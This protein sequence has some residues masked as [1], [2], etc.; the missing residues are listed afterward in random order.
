MDDKTITQKG[1]WYLVFPKSKPSNSALPCNAM[2][3]ATLL[4]KMFSNYQFFSLKIFFEVQNCFLSAKNYSKQI[5]LKKLCVELNGHVTSS[6][7]GGM[8]SCSLFSLEAQRTI[9]YSP[10]TAD[11]HQPNSSSAIFLGKGSI[12]FAVFSSW[13]LVNFWCFSLHNLSASSFQLL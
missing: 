6:H 13:P 10:F 2:S 11:D 8:Y 4:T 5:H 7:G 9:C 12:C 1:C 3:S